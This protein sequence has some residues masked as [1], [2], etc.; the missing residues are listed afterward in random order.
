MYKLSVLF[1]L[2]LF[3][4]CKNKL[5]DI[6]QS[7][8]KIEINRFEKDLFQI[9][10]SS[11]TE[12]LKM[13]KQKHASFF[14][15]FNH[16]IIEIGS[17]KSPAYSDMI[18]RFLTDYSVY[19]AYEAS[20]AKFSDLSKVEADLSQAFS[21]FKYY[22]P[23]KAIPQF[24]SFVAGFNQSVVTD[25]GIIGIGLDKYLGADHEMYKMMNPPY[26]NYF[27]YRMIPERIAVD[28][29]QGWLY[30][31]FPYNDSVNNLLNNMVYEGII[32]YAVSKMFPN[33]N[34][35]LLFAYTPEQLAFVEDNEVQ[36]WT[37]LIEH[38]QLFENDNFIIR[39]YIGEAPFTK[40]FGSGS[41]GKAVI[42]L[43]KEIVSSYMKKHKN[44]SLEELL[45][46]TD[47]LALLNAS[48]YNP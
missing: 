47:Y 18:I 14:E 38:K 25:E 46:T 20:E 36:M 10:L 37:F 24:Y 16:K 11:P 12:D 2:L 9:S 26:P 35:T 8:V 39:Q 42:W 4:S 7:E 6:S 1:L 17:S 48:A 34:D 19:K 27:T 13:I 31:E 5:P 45:L 40:N 30:S 23:D 29:M 15:L 43:G 32:N 33:A 44:V 21:Y 28:C 41:P 22:F 3:I